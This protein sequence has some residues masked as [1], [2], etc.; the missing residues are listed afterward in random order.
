VGITD[1]IDELINNDKIK[2][3]AFDITVQLL[4]NERGELTEKFE[5]CKTT[6]TSDV[7][8]VL[9]EASK[10]EKWI[11]KFQ[12]ISNTLKIRVKKD[13]LINSACESK[14]E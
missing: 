6:Q 7:V 13:G 5:L 8:R 2:Q 14:N 11:K 1:R 4:L 10:S 3:L 12:V 9:R